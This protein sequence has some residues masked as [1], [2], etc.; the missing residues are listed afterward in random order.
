MPELPE[1]EV[2]KRSLKKKIL[3]QKIKRIKI[4]NRNLR[5]KIPITFNKYLKNRVI[6]DISRLS[7]YIIFHLDLSQG[8]YAYPCNNPPDVMTTYFRSHGPGPIYANIY[9]IP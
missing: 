7:K 9:P 6:K 4:Y 1:V 5:Y 2:L 8:G 3:F